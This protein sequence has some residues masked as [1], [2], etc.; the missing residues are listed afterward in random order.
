MAINERIS[1]VRKALGMNLRDFSEKIGVSFTSVSKIE[2]GINNPSE[3]TIRLICSVYNVNYRWLKDGIAA[4]PDNPTDDD[5]FLTAVTDDDLVER[6][7]FGEN[8]FAKS[9]MREFAKLGDAQWRMLE[10]LVRG[11][12][13]GLPEEKEN[14]KVESGT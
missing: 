7:M 6:V 4:D 13:A 10:K 5:I 9:V 14:E 11:I 3:R 12:V 2:T 1:L 8:E